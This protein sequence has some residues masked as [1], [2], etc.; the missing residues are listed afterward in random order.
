MPPPD[1][2]PAPACSAPPCRSS[3]HT[4]RRQQA[5]TPPHTYLKAARHPPSPVTRGKEPPAPQGGAEGRRLQTE[6]KVELG[7]N[8]VL[9]TTAP[10]SAAVAA[11]KHVMGPNKGGGKAARSAGKR[12]YFLEAV[13]RSGCEIDASEMAL[14]NAS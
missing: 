7:P 9:Q 8:R 10:T 14:G 11:P 6:R 4:S 2:T 12:E 5:S 3:D 13:A 1:P